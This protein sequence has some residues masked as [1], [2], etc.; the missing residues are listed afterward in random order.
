MVYFLQYLILQIFIWFVHLLPWKLAYFLGTTLG[1]LLYFV[2]KP[3]KNLVM[4]NLDKAR[5]IDLNCQEKEKLVHQIYRNFSKTLIESIKI[6]RWDKKIIDK[7]VKIEGLDNLRQAKEKNKGIILLT[8][9]IGNWH[10]MG[11]ALTLNGYPVNKV[12]KRQK[13]PWVANWIAAQIRRGKMKSIFQNSNSPR[14]IIKA[15]RNGDVVEFLGDLHAG[16][17][18]LFV[19][20]LGRP[21]STYSGPVVLA[22][23]T[24]A[25]IVIAVD[26]RLKDNT[27]QVFIE[28]PVY[29]ETGKANEEQVRKELS[30]LTKRLEKYIINYPD[31]WF[32]LHNRWKTQPKNKVKEA[33]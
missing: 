33:S 23:R 31:Q 5:D 16:D 28:E 13:N 6:S 30:L 29:L 1:D 9:H 10:V 32:W 15:L 2:I 12:I 27:H 26:V 21:A 17:A 24:G 22:M 7:V 8:E 18:G 11:M 3:R 25:P 14:E 4:E 20:F 19:D